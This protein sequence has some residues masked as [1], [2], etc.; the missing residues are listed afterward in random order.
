MKALQTLSRLAAYALAVVVTTLEM[1]FRRSG[2]VYYL[3]P[4]DYPTLE[5]F[6][7]NIAAVIGKIE[8]IEQPLYDRIQYPTAG[9]AQAQ[10]FSVPIGAGQSSESAAAAGTT[11]TL[12]DTNM[13]Q[14]GQLPAPQA[15]WVENIQ[16]FVDAG[17][18]A[19]ANTY[20]TQNP[21]A[22]AAAAAATVQAGDND[23]NLILNSGVAIFSVGQKPYFRAAPLHIFPPQSRIRLDAAVSSNSATVGEVLKAK[24][25]ADGRL[26]SLDP[27]VGIA[28]GFNFDVTLLFP[29]LQA[30]PSGFNA[31][32]ACHLGGWLF[33][34]AQ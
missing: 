12:A 31:R 13:T 8:V 9:L 26:R 16:I 28:T 4:Q 11:K 1:A 30:T 22:F 32:I 7:A 2:F 27:G 21:T 18:V 29:V 3:N 10:F 14:N 34:A 23:V 25:Y 15:F 20:T 17:S 5:Q 33:R 19:T 24:I 6:A